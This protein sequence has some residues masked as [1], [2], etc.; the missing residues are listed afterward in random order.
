MTQTSAG[1]VD[2]ASVGSV[3]GWPAIRSRPRWSPERR[4]A[5]ARR[6]RGCSV[7]PG[8][9]RARRPAGRP[10]PRARRSLRR[11]RGARRRPR[12]RRRAGRVRRADHVAP[13]EPIDLVVNNAGFGTS[14]DFHELDSERLEDEI[15]LNVSAL[16]TLS[17][18]ALVGDGA[19]PSRLPAQR[20]ERG[21][22]PAGARTRRVRG[23]QGVRDEP[24]RGL[25]EEVTRQR[26]A[27]HGAVPGPDEDRVPERSNTE[28]YDD[29]VSRLRVDVGRVGRRDR[30]RRRRQEARCRCPARSTRARSAPASITPRFITRRLSGLAGRT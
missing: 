6:W 13:S 25:H 15:E 12:D 10:P 2:R 22:L 5:S 26:R 3:A 20:V 4:R 14:G 21:Q 27:R 23:D 7:R 1:A 9:D 24:D 8:P 11:L 30:A 18:A 29:D 16:T 17:H 19:T 28:R